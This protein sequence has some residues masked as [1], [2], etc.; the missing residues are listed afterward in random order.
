M[1]IEYSSHFWEQFNVRK[2]TSPIELTIEIIEDTIKNPDFV[3][4]DRKPYREGRIKKIQGR[5]LKVIVEKEL[6]KF[7]VITIFWDRTLRRKGLC[8]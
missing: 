6:D 4:K 8:K 5:C 3:I 2:E 1:K 7:K